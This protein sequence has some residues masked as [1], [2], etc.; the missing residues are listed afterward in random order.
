M[1]WKI[2]I[3]AWALFFLGLGVELAIDYALRMQDGNPRTGGLSPATYYITQIILFLCAFFLSVKGTR[4]MKKWFSRVIVVSI[5]VAIGSV[6][7]LWAL[8]SY[9]LNAGID[10]LWCL[11]RTT[12]RSRLTSQCSGRGTRCRFVCM[13]ASSHYRTQ[14]APAYHAADWGVMWERATWKSTNS[15]IRFLAWM[16][17]TRPIKEKINHVYFIVP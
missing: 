4:S 10:S 2:T 17:W 12:L 5:Q 7:Y 14:T 3:F 13:F 15:R 11:S 16:L 8:Y 6:L 9:V 1:N